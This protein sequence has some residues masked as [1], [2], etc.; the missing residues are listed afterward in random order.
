MC[1]LMIIGLA[2]CNQVK[3]PINGPIEKDVTEAT[4]SIATTEPITEPTTEK[5]TE[6]LI[7]EQMHASETKPN[8]LGE[9]MIIM[10]HNLAKENSSY[11]RTIESFKE[12]LEKLYSGGYRLISMA[13]YL[14]GKIDIPYGYTPV[15]LTFD[16]G[17]S[18]NFKYIENADGEWII[19]PDSVIGILEDFAK[20]HPD[21]GKSA[22]FYLNAGNPFGQPSLLQ[23]KLDFLSA[24]GYEI[25]NHAYDH[26]D[27][28]KLDAE[29]IQ[30]AL[31]RNVKKFSAIQPDL[32]MRT[33]A[34]PYGKAPQSD[35]L[36]AYVSKGAYEDVVYEN[37]LTLLVGWRPTVPFYTNDFDHLA[38]HRVQSGDG[39]M[40]LTWWLNS[41][42][43][44]PERR[45]ISDG[46]ADWITIPEHLY[47]KLDTS[48]IDTEKVLLI[49]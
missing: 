20:E 6:M 42:E 41:Y 48:K 12:D 21:F 44:N 25:G 43:E 2:G 38:V 46:V 23:E 37:A 29:G 17:H 9:I 16:D 32:K 34:L 5:T 30:E 18:T 28:S 45:F 13:S 11:A 7:L 10:Y 47:E 27:L 4:T 49:E 15:L 40:Q 3:E 33:L 26:E 22:V 14:S 24:N 19:D 31:G 1:M 39:E 36:K 8:E 35:D